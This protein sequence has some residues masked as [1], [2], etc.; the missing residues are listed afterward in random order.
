MS[1]Y[2]FQDKDK[3]DQYKNDNGFKA[4]L[5]GGE[6]MV[7]FNNDTVFKEFLKAPSVN[8]PIIKTQKAMKK[9]DLEFYSYFNDYYI[10][11]DKVVAGSRP[12][13]DGKDISKSFYKTSFDDIID[14]VT[15]AV[16]DTQLLSDKE[17]IVKD[18]RLF[19]ILS[20]NE[21]C[22]FIDTTKFKLRKFDNTLNDDDST[23]DVN[24]YRIQEAFKE[25][26]FNY[27]LYT[28]QIKMA[29]LKNL[30]ILEI[31]A[32]DDSLPE[33]I[34]ESRNKI[35]N[36]FDKDITNIYEASEELK[37]TNKKIVF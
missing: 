32:E 23:Y 24:M 30:D 36:F 9:L 1:N 26:I 13:F 6:A 34:D 19:N 4:K 33:F 31:L 11:D 14:F 12:Y 35:C 3:L 28:L 22:K 7:Y 27:D 10:I 25:A 29:L 21:G 17:T 5:L 18:A 15:D 8:D 20:N 37:K 2:V 16:F